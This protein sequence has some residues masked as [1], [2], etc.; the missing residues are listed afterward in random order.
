V[1]NDRTL[2]LTYDEDA[3]QVVLEGLPCGPAGEAG[4]SIADG[5]E[6]SFDSADGRLCGVFIDAGEPGQPPVV[7][8]PALAAVA[9]LFGSRG[10]AAIEQAS[11]KQRDPVTVAA[12][13]EVMAAMSRLARLD[14]VR[15]TSP[16]TDSPLWAVEAAQLARRAGLDTRLRA[17]AL[18]AASALE[19]ADHVPLVVL[20]SAADA[21]ADLVEL[22]EAELAD[23]L[24]KHAAAFRSAGVHHSRGRSRAVPGTAAEDIQPGGD[25]DGPPGWLDPRL[26]P[27]GIFRHALAPDADLTIRTD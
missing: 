15:V 1:T 26:I 16:V 11:S 3:G 20:E 22:V 24:R 17:E 9:G 19:Q 18:R 7:G 10:C 5:I 6:L 27:P 14:S 8:T 21:I 4:L 12:E 25:S 13:P 2:T 23:T